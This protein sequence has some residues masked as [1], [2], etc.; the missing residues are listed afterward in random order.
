MNGLDGI[1]HGIG[2][3]ETRLGNRNC[4]ITLVFELD[5]LNYWAMES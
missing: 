3:S 1:Q 4:M 5:L 2:S